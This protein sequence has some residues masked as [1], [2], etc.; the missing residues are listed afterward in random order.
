MLPNLF[1][2]L[3]G[4]GALSAALIPVYTEQLYKDK[5]SA[6]ALANSV[7]TLL[8][9]VLAALT[10]LGLG[11]IYLYWNLSGG[12]P[13]TFL[14]LSMAAIMLPYLI[15]ICSVATIGGM[16]NV[17]RHFAAPAAAPILLNICI[18]CAAVF[19][20]KLFGSD[21]W[22]QIYVV[23]IA[24]LAAGV[25]QLLL[26]YPALRAVG[27]SLRPRFNFSEEPL[28]R[29]IRLMGPMVIGLAA[30]QINAY[31]DF[32]IAHWLSG[33]PESGPVFML[34]GNEIQYPVLEG[35][36][37]FLYYSQRLYHLPLGIFGLALATAIFPV[38]SRHAACKEY[39]SFAKTL[40]QGL[41]L[42]FFI[43]LPATV[44]LI[45]IRRP[46]TKLLFERGEFTSY[47]TEQVATTLLFYALGI[48]AYFLQQLVVRA[49]Y[50]YQDSVTPVK[51]AMRMI[52]LNLLLN[53]LLIWPLATGGLALS[54]SLC[55]TLQVI[56]LLRILI[57]RYGLDLA[58]GL[59]GSVIKTTIATAVMAVGGVF[60][61]GG[62]ADAETFVQVFGAVLV[63]LVL[64]V[65]MSLLLKN[66]EVYALIRRK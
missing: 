51:I 24:V 7:V 25:F 64:F 20:R 58:G 38:L 62:L 13:K 26:Q 57:K 45:L 56:I 4:E 55:A 60:C 40:A 16:L 36:A 18:I 6:R 59:A 43:A 28:R 2:R 1:R 29:V 63:C 12:Q 35:S 50:S 41:R 46:L 66:P 30:M 44:G 54:T 19:F 61:L 10:L 9:I 52:A 33:T 42:V 39:D 3:F 23:A 31:F 17:H 65:G 49:Y 14:I 37:S 11:F 5:R 32:L 48:T 53:V 34:F 15:F 27:L 22:R 47:D 8:V 21:P